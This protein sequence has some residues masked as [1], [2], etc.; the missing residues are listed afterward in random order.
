MKGWVQEGLRPTLKARGGVQ[1]VGFE[2]PLLLPFK[3]GLNPLYPPLPETLPV[4]LPRCW[5]QVAMDS[6]RP[7][8]SLL[9]LP[10][11]ESS[12]QSTL[13]DAGRMIPSAVPASSA[14]AR[15]AH[16]D[17]VVALFEGSDTESV[18]LAGD[19][20]LSAPRPRRRLVLVSEEVETMPDRNG[21]GQLWPNR[22]WP[23]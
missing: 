8:R 3:R 15:A 22:L 19:E 5:A 1:N 20:V 6:R 7:R 11:S 17:E 4:A 18:R 13:E 12:L 14:V 21:H 10:V 16:K 23:I 2:T 9:G